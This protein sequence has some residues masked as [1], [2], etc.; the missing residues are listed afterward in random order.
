MRYLSL[1]ALFSLLLPAPDAL[2]QRPGGGRPG[3]APTG[4]ITG[5]VTDGAT[6]DAL[7]GAT[8]A[9]WSLPD[10]ALVTGAITDFDGAFRLDGVQPGGYDLHVTFVGYRSQD[11]GVQLAPRQR[12]ALEPV[13]LAVD[14]ELL[15]GVEVLGERAVVEQRIDRTV[16]STEDQAVTT[17]GNALDVLQ[18]VPSLEVDQN[19]ALSLRGSQNVVVQING[20]PVPVRGDQLSG[21]LR[22][23]PAE[24]VARVEVIPNPSAKYEPDGMSGIVNIVLKEGSRRGLGGSLALTGNQLGGGEANGSVSYGTTKTDLYLGYGFR[25]NQDEGSGFNLRDNF[26]DTDAPGGFSEEDQFGADEEEGQ[27]H[28][29]NLQADYRPRPAPRSRPRA[30]CPS[31]TRPRTAPSAT[32]S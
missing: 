29:L 30:S 9:L 1:L 5:S 20:R 25:Y 13:V 12:L 26:Y 4:Q 23:L 7:I 8:V 10:S 21:L 14:A 24:Q 22:S 2:A 15:E 3:G 19:G 16:Y 11:I 31:A 27:S 6:G 17:G 28:S 18:T 32:S